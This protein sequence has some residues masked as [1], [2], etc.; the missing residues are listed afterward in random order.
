ML[1]EW[2]GVVFEVGQGSVCVRVCVVGDYTDE[3]IGICLYE[4][5]VKFTRPG[6]PC[7]DATFA[8][9]VCAA[10]CPQ[11]LHSL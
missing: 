10:L 1:R 9:K 6:F 7:P 4:S 11:Q 2:L 5:Q 8:L 3:S